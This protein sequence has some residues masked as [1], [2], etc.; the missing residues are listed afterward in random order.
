MLLA[1]GIN[2]IPTIEIYLGT[3]EL[4]LTA[5]RRAAPGTRCPAVFTHTSGRSSQ[6]AET[7]S[8]T[9][10]LLCRNGRICAAH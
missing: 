7:L 3:R 2:E 9:V 10:F 8:L 1:P 6:G 4:L 5:S